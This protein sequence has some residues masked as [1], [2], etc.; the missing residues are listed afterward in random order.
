MIE[1]FAM[2]ISIVVQYENIN[3]DLNEIRLYIWNKTNILPGKIK[4]KL[5]ASAPK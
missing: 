1:D 2:N 5:A 4:I 3:K